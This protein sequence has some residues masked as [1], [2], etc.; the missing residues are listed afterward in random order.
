[1]DEDIP[2]KK[3]VNKYCAFKK[4]TESILAI[5]YESTIEAAQI[6]ADNFFSSLDIFVEVKSY[7]TS[8]R[9]KK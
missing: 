2:K 9:L 5:V 4:G 6:Q 1:M 7:Q 8:K 3:K